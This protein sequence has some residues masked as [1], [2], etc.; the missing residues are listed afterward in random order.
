MDPV[1][2]FLQ[3]N[4]LITPLFPPTSRYHGIAAAQLTLADGTTIAYLRRR[5]VPPPENFA[6][7][8]EHVVA[9]GDR[10]DNLAARYL[11]DPLQYWRLCD[12]NRAM[13]PDELTATAGRLL[14]IT[15]PEGIPG[16]TDAG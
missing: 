2:A 7:L 16:V 8:Q 3:A 5:F 14:R 4:A 6:L 13:R 10:L 9:A 1:Q 12:A 15:L 11:G